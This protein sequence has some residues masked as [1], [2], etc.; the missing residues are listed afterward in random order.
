[1]PEHLVSSSVGIRDV[2]GA[3][4]VSVAFAAGCF[5]WLAAT[6][7]GNDARPEGLISFDPAATVVLTKAEPH[8]RC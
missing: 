5:T 8:G 2:I 3:W 6:A 4:L 1:M 7:P